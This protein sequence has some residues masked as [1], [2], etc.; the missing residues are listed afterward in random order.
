MRRQEIQQGW[1]G[2]APRKRVAHKQPVIRSFW[3]STEGFMQGCS[4]AVHP[5]RF[6]ARKHRFRRLESLR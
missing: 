5:D 2:Y 4:G 6:S 1:N 3:N